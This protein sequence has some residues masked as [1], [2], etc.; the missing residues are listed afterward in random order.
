MKPDPR[1]AAGHRDAAIWGRW[2]EEADRLGG[3]EQI[4]ALGDG[5]PEHPEAEA[6]RHREWQ[7]RPPRRRQAAERQAKEQPHQ[8]PEEEAD[9]RGHELGRGE[10]L[11]P[12]DQ[13]GRGHDRQVRQDRETDHQPGNDP[14]REEGARVLVRGEQTLARGGQHQA[15]E[16]AER[17]AQDTDVTDQ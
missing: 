5:Q 8:Q 4:P 13:P 3:D 10:R 1:L 11:D 15:D 6:D 16:P 17:G 12:A 14:Y 2:P 9:D 7:P